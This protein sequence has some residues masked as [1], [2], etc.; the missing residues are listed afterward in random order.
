MG[1]ELNVTNGD[2]AIKY[3][4][5]YRS[6][7]GSVPKGA[8]T[9]C[10][11]LVTAYDPFDIDVEWRNVLKKVYYYKT[12]KRRKIRR[13][14]YQTIPYPFYIFKKKSRTVKEWKLLLEAGSKVRKELRSSFGLDRY[15][16][17]LDQIEIRIQWLIERLKPFKTCES[18]VVNKIRMPNDVQS[19]DFSSQ[20]VN[21]ST[22]SADVSDYII[23]TGSPTL[24]AYVHSLSDPPAGIMRG[25]TIQGTPVDSYDPPNEDIV[26][27]IHNALFYGP[28]NELVAQDTLNNLTAMLWPSSADYAEENSKP[29]IDLA[30]GL[31]DASFPLGDPPSPSEALDKFNNVLPDSRLSAFREII[32]FS[33]NALLWNNLVVGP[34]ISSAQGFS[35]S[36]KANDLAI[37]KFTKAAKS[38]RWIQ[39]KNLR[40][41]G[42]NPMATAIAFG[43]S[44]TG[45]SDNTESDTWIKKL[46]YDITVD[47][48]EANA[49]LIYKVSIEDAWNMNSSKMRLSQFFNR[50]ASSFDAVLHELIP[51]S[52]VV[53]WFTSDYTGELN[54]DQKV[55][56]PL[57]DWKLIVSH[58]CQYD[59]RGEPSAS[60][61]Y[62]AGGL[63]IKES[64]ETE[65]T[66]WGPKNVPGH[67]PIGEDHWFSYP[68]EKV[69]PTSH[70]TIPSTQVPSSYETCEYYHRMVYNKPDYTLGIQDPKVVIPH[71]ETQKSP[72]AGQLFT[73][74]A[75]IWG[76]I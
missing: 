1:Y 40:L 30:E 21:V 37:D 59:I 64:W 23:S 65:Y 24:G 13:Y 12:F 45:Y 75:L 17:V 53:D 5:G 26:N 67:L 62:S 66:Y 25:L 38:G 51:L 56:M 34:L 32:D 28:V 4:Y 68:R 8:K 27:S 76:Q 18:L 19:L 61:K 14:K 73:L 74:G 47:A 2:H 9:N 16:E 35:T 7:S 50:L 52:F 70:N 71:L 20:P 69:I 31:S 15:L 60:H 3:I 72:T 39:G 57:D 11:V 10:D 36:V 55:Y 46:K 42:E 44:P 43:L 48:L 49:S 22:V 63:W 58:K 33:A 54:L 6:N 41:W 29:L